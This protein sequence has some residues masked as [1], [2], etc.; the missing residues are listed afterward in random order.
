MQIVQPAL[1]WLAVAALAHGEGDVTAGIVGVIG[2][3]VLLEWQARRRPGGIPILAG[4]LGVAAGIGLTH[5]DPWATVATAGVTAIWAHVRRIWPIAGPEQRGSRPSRRLSRPSS[6]QRPWSRLSPSAPRSSPLG[7][8]PSRIHRSSVPASRR[9]VPDVV[10]VLAALLVVALTLAPEL[11]AGGAAIA[12]GLSAAALAVNRMPVAARAW[13]VVPTL[14]W[15]AWL[16]LDAAGLSVDTIAAS[17]AIA[18]ALLTAVATWRKGVAEHVAAAAVIVSGLAFAA[19]PGG[20]L[21]FDVLCVLVAALGS[22]TVAGELREV[23]V[24]D[25]LVRAGASTR[26][27]ALGRIVPPALFLAGLAG[28]CLVASDASGLLVDRPA[29]VGVIL[30]GLA[31]AEAGATWLFRRRS[32]LRGVV[33][34]GAFALAIAGAVMAAAEPR[35]S[36]LALGLSIVAVAALAPE[37]R[38][39]PMSWTAWAT[40]FVLIAR[41]TE[42]ADLTIED[43][44]LAVAGWSAALL[45]GGLLLDDR[46]AG[47]RAPGAFVRVRETYGSGRARRSRLLARA[48]ARDA[49]IRRSGRGGRDWRRPGGRR[50]RDTALARRAHGRDVPPADARGRGPVAVLG[51]RSSRVGPAV[52]RRAAPGRPGDAR[53]LCRTRTGASLGSAAVRSGT[54]GR[55]ASGWLRPLSSMNWL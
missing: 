12:A 47:R 34:I 1:L 21:R 28:L 16:A 13:I 9:R 23:G 38:W 8:W 51:V 26:T 46:R 22:I 55:P 40:S 43:A 10:D 36:A 15:T 49:R 6:S 32:P 4:V 27:G 14:A 2:S 11:P 48:R 3:L 50:G 18:A 31:V 42:L 24:T 7:H 29:V 54:R 44:A 41:I 5:S 53:H 30:T 20:W 19:I 35:P 25:L 39:E 37:S 52:G 45:V 33:A 17:V